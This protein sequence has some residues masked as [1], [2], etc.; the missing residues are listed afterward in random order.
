MKRLLLAV[1]L[2]AG[3]AGPT[4][5]V[6]LEF[7]DVPSDVLLGAQQ[8]P[9]PGGPGIRVPLPAPPSVVSLPP[10][11]FEVRPGAEPPPLVLP[12]PA[13]CPSP[14]LLAAPELEATPTLAKPPVPGAYVYDNAG[15]YAITGANARQGVFPA[16]TLRVLGNVTRPSS[17][18]FTFDVSELI[19]D[20]TTTTTYRVV[21]DSLTPATGNGLY[22]E[23]V[24]Y[25]RSNGQ[26]AQFA[27][28][29]FP[30]LAALPLVRGATSDQR[31]VDPQSQTVMT[32]TTT[33]EGKAR[34]Y[35]CGTPLD[36]WTIHLTKGS[37]TSP[38]QSLQFDSTYQVGSQ[39]GGLSLS[40]AIAYTGTD[41]G[42][43]VTRSNRAT[44]SS[45]PR[46]P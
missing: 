42:D 39:F 5:P 23:K 10:P 3:C 29:Q 26:S 14:D 41:N 4:R 46:T 28:L 44:I 33:V 9:T 34:V 43:G 38:T 6:D 37:I 18:S 13:S 30:L 40:D 8:T 24:T 32:F 35:A 20:T 21:N 25:R 17:G 7:K 31:A 12:T 16:R 1:L 15:S 27:P 19:G 11:P 2:V 45:V 36:S 22:L